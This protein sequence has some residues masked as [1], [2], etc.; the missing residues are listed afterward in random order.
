MNQTT[1][2]PGSKPN[3]AGQ[4]QTARRIGYI[5]SIVVMIVVI[6]VLRHLRQ[7]GVTFLN[8]DF[9][10]ALFYI[11][12]SIYVSIA[13]NALFIL[14]DH[15]WFKHLLQGIANI[16]SALALIMIYVI[17]PFDIESDTWVKWIKIALLI[18]FGLSVL[19]TLAELIKGFRDLTRNPEKI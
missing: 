18:L 16:F 7:W 6:Y 13:A 19:G 11:E 15:R 5:V 2:K 17:F 1:K 8:E 12:L 3:R 9:E 14:Y 10:N 4:S